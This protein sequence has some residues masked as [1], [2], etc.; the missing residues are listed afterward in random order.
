MI[1]NN[2]FTRILPYGPG[3]QE[4]PELLVIH[5]MAEFIDYNGEILSAFD[6]L[7]RLRLSAHKLAYPSGVIQT[8]RHDLQGAWHAKGF[9]TKSL[10]I[11]V[12]VPGVHDYNS[13]LKAMQEDWV[14]ETQYQAVLADC[15]EW[16]KLWPIKRVETHHNLDPTRK[17]DPGPGFPMKRLIGDLQW[18][19]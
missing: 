16:M 10:G 19:Q 15:Q 18:H 3:S 11:E 9:N 5:A 4:P 12:L 6:L 1:N 14:G 8:T 17:Y 7:T 13:F 2:R